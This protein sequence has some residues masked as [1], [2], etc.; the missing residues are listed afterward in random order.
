MAIVP[1][2]DRRPDDYWVRKRRYSSFFDTD[3]EILL[4]G[5]KATTLLMVGGL[6]GRHV[7]TTRLPTRISE[8][9]SAVSS[10]TAWPD[11]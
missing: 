4:R 5:L 2:V 9:M 11:R 8:I 6:L 3:L 10:K 7:R 1:E